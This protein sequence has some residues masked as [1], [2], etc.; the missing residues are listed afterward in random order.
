M[1]SIYYARKTIEALGSAGDKEKG[2][3][4]SFRCVVRH[5]VKAILLLFYGVEFSVGVAWPLCVRILDGSFEW[6]SDSLGTGTKV[7]IA[8]V[9]FILIAVGVLFF[10]KAIAS[11]QD[12]A[13][14][15]LLNN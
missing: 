9:G 5:G 3:S 13:E 2:K 7:G 10:F 14:G 12:L 11:K 4:G 1:F 6:M 8:L 15:N